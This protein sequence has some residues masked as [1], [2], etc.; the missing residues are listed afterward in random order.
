M[1]RLIEMKNEVYRNRNRKAF[2]ESI[3][4]T[5]LDW[6]GFDTKEDILTYLHRAINEGKANEYI[7]RFGNKQALVE[8]IT[9]ENI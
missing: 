9:N 7:N 1:S 8:H 5:E 3:G 4:D 2:I 6:M